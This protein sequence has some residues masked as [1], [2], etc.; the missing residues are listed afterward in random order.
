MLSTCLTWLYDSITL[1]YCQ[2]ISHNSVKFSVD[3]SP[4]TCYTPFRR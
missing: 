1:L 3:S 2:Y 4:C